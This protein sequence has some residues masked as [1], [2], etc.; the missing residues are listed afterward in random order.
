V[1]SVP[2]AARAWAAGPPVLMA[3]VQ[4]RVA[5][6]PVRVAAPGAPAVGV[7]A[8]ALLAIQAT[9]RGSETLVRSMANTPE[10]KVAGALAIS[11]GMAMTAH[12]AMVAATAPTMAMA[13]TMA[14]AAR[15]MAAGNFGDCDE[16]V[17]EVEGYLSTSRSLAPNYRL[18]GDWLH[19]LNTMAGGDRA[20][21]RDGSRHRHWRVPCGRIPTR[22]SAPRP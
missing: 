4:A 3:V 15:V 13:V 8:A 7:A 11:A 21:R 16:A 22:R 10:A 9:T 6:P 12:A 14:G 5:G 19:E 1:V 18:E 20:T 2:A 17:Y